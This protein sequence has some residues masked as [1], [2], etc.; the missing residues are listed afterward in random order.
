MRH[1]LARRASRG[2]IIAIQQVNGNAAFSEDVALFIDWENF[3]IS[4]AVRGR[5]PNVSALKEEVSNHGRVVVGKAYADWVSR[6]PELKGASQFIHDPPSLYAAGIEPVYVP[7]R[8][9]L[10]GSYQSNR[11]V[12][13]KNSVDVKMTADCIDTAH[14]F[15]N[16]NTFVLVSGDS[17]FIHVI[18]SLRAVGKRVLVVGVSWATSRRMADHVDGLIFYDADVDP[19]EPEEPAPSFHRGPA[20]RGRPQQPAALANPGRHQLPEVI[21]A[22]E[23]VIRTERAAGH[24]LLL[25][26][27]KQRLV[28]RIAGFDERKL[29]FSGFK[30]LMLRVAEEGNIKIRSVDL[31]DW[32]LMADEPDPE[33]VARDDDDAE[34]ETADS[35]DDVDDAAEDADDRVAGVGDR[36]DE[37]E[38]SDDDDEVEDDRSGDRMTAAARTN[39]PDRVAPAPADPDQAKIERSLAEAIAAMELPESGDPEGDAARIADLVA[40]SH[41]L[42]NRDGADAVMFQAL[43]NEI[44]ENLTAGIEAEDATIRE[45]WGDSTDLVARNLITRYVRTLMAVGLFQYRNI[46]FRDPETNRARRRRVFGLNREHPVVGFALAARLGLPYEPPEDDHA[47]PTNDAIA[48]PPVDHHGS[49]EADSAETAEDAEVVAFS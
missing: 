26:S 49:A 1:P 27:L 3:K 30:K 45:H 31:V 6:A 19:I 39:E 42:E 40:M 23:D 5:T 8:L 2:N 24:T 25:T 11:T 33:P 43:C 7:T 9:P 34:L 36:S 48:A 35:Y 18:N 47:P 38:D 20:Q 17:D 28:R 12:S 15:P 37:L 41:F 13:V 21:R 4:L 22:I 44:S 29:G 46:N 16:I 32:I 14:N 10:R